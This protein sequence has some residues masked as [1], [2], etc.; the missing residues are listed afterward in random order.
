MRGVLAIIVY[1]ETIRH[2][3]CLFPEFSRSKLPLKIFF[4]TARINSVQWELN[5]RERSPNLERLD[6]EQPILPNFTISNGIEIHVAEVRNVQR[7]IFSAQTTFISRVCTLL[8]HASVETQIKFVELLG[9]VT[10]A[11]F[12]RVFKQ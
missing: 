11:D 9:K 8:T 1:T 10:F 4:L 5:L 6:I 2:S 12:I 7:T 3:N